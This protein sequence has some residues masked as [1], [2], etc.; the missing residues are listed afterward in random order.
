MKQHRMC[1]TRKGRGFKK[2][3]GAEIGHC[4]VVLSDGFP[5]L[6]HRDVFTQ[7]QM[8]FPLVLLLESKQSCSLKPS[9]VEL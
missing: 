4:E 7:W 6:V 2:K 1:V 3:S 8:S 9:E 5:R